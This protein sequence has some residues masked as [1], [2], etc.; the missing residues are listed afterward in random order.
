M[1]ETRTRATRLLEAAPF[2]LQ[3][4]GLAVLFGFLLGFF[5]HADRLSLMEDLQEQGKVSA[6]SP[7][8][9]ELLRRFG[10]RLETEVEE[11]GFLLVSE[12]ALPGRLPQ[13]YIVLDVGWGEPRLV[14]PLD[15]VAWWAFEDD[16]AFG[17][18]GALLLAFG[19]A[20]STRRRLWVQGPSAEA[21]AA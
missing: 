2:W 8:G 21:E 14:A 16:S 11:P 6:G 18:L 9:R 13:K 12:R 17:W 20:A 15:E 7:A 3:W 10:M 1:T 5:Q 4:I 19:L